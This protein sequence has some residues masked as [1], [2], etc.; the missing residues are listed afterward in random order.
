VLAAAENSESSGDAN[1]PPII[2]ALVAKGI[3]ASAAAS[4][5]QLLVV[6]EQVVGGFCL[7]HQIAISRRYR[8]ECRRWYGRGMAAC[9]LE[10]HALGGHSIR[11]V[12]AVG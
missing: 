4:T 2:A 8:R 11:R 12:A 1:M 6:P 5:D 10:L 3:C 9:E 7:N